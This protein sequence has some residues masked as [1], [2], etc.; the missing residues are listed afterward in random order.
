MIRFLRKHQ[1]IFF[2]IIT[3]V[4]VIT[5]SFFGT[6]SVTQNSKGPKD[7][8]L[9]KALNGKD[10]RFLQTQKL[11][12]LL[13]NDAHSGNIS[14]LLNKDILSKEFVDTGIAKILAKHYFGFI[15]GY[16]QEHFDK[17]NHYNLYTHPHISDISVENVWKQY[18]PEL[19]SVFNKIKAAKNVDET[20]F[21][22]L[23]NAYVLQEQFSP[24][25]LKTLLYY[26]QM[27]YRQANLT[28]YE[29]MHNDF[30]LF[31]FKNV[32]DWFGQNF[33]DLLSEF[34]LNVAYI[35]EDKGYTAKESEVYEEL[36]TNLKDNLE[37]SENK[38]L[39]PQDLKSAFQYQCHLLGMKTTDVIDV[40][41]RV[42]L[43]K[44]YFHD[45]A[46]AVF[47]D[48]ILDKK[49]LDMKHVQLDV[50]AY[51]LPAYLMIKDS[52]ERSYLALYWSCVGSDPLYNKY[53][54]IEQIEEKYP[55]LIQRK[56]KV[57]Y[58]SL[59]Q[60]EAGLNI[61]E[62]VLWQWQTKKENWQKL[63]IKFPDLKK[64]LVRNPFDILESISLQ[65][66][67]RID[68]FSRG[69]MVKEKALIEETLKKQEKKELVIKFKN[70]GTS[71]DAPIG[72]NDMQALFA[73]LNQKDHSQIYTQD[74]TCY[75]LFG[76]VSEIE[77]KHIITFEEAFSDGSL[78]SL[79]DKYV[80][81]NLQAYKTN[82]V[83]EAKKSIVDKVFNAESV[84]KKLLSYMEGLCC[85]MRDK[86]DDSFVFHG[87]KR[88][89]LNQWMLEKE[90]KTINKGEEKAIDNAIVDQT[91]NV[92][93]DKNSNPVFY[94][95][96]KIKV[97]E[98]AVKEEMDKEKQVLI[99]EVKL[100]LAEK[101]IQSMLDK[102]AFLL[103]IRENV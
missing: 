59:T 92:S 18:A 93:M 83:D 75:Y 74:N 77:T 70:K 91:V 24:Q 63:L 90:D 10:I 6:Y 60:E 5:F 22:D 38:Q 1:R 102:K 15:K 82:S 76:D 62:K 65:L 99:N 69:E 71:I 51:K 103:P 47:T 36:V 78:K 30:Y 50:S 96:N 37:K 19:L 64:Q 49:L 73:F 86:K 34:I 57:Q 9:V 23:L 11:S 46:T 40:W 66:R 20:F 88:D 68:S 3:V 16:L 27:E 33:V 8:V 84:D 2:I 4:I 53:Y 25:M 17:I 7:K 72:I 89:I 48:N 87:D 39:F 98:K 67:N 21:G 97:D 85:Q 28:D 26:Q 31:G 52:M 61:T 80:Q 81:D 32:S 55:E 94:H 100:R 54:P 95:I 41:Q 79:L 44:K 101:I 14:N 13:S 58:A 45:H 12:I 35:A 42:L 56:I 29:F 43:F